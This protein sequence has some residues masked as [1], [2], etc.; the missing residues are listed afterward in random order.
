M[1][2]IRKS[3]LIACAAGYTYNR[4]YILAAATTAEKDVRYYVFNKIRSK[5]ISRVRIGGISP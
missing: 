5:Y 1:N 4:L 3:L 2:L